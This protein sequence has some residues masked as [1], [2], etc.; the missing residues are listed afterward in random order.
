MRTAVEWFH[1][2]G[3]PSLHNLVCSWEA[4]YSDSEVIEFIVE[5]QMDALSWALTQI[6]VDGN[7]EAARTK[8]SSAIDQLSKTK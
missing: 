4:D 1:T 8:I 6:V 5:I 7:P 2:E 3:G